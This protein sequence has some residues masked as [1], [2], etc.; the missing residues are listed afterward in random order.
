MKFFQVLSLCSLALA[1]PSSLSDDF[2]DDLSGVDEFSMDQIS[3]L[4][5]LVA[6]AQGSSVLVERAGILDTVGPLLTNMTSIVTGNTQVLNNTLTSIQNSVYVQLSALV[7]ANLESIIAAIQAAVK[8]ILSQ[9]AGGA[10]GV[11]QGVASLGSADLQALYSAVQGA[12]NALN[13]IHVAL[14]V[15]IINLAPVVLNTLKT[16]LQAAQAAIGPVLAPIQ[17]LLLAFLQPAVIANLNVTGV[18]NLLG[19]FNGILA[20]V[21]SVL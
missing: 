19:S 10:S 3:A 16:E 6:E 21:K 8:G 9:T 7:Q 14:T 17:A 15:T 2:S 20:F 5:K 4:D 18:Q 1:V 12:I 11:L 13:A